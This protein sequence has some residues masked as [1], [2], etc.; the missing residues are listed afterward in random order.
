MISPEATE[1]RDP[2]L[3]DS[4]SDKKYKKIKQKIN[5]VINNLESN[6]INPGSRISAASK[7]AD[8][9]PRAG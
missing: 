6:D 9:R 8:G 7:L 4:D 2:E 5:F 3:N 1:M